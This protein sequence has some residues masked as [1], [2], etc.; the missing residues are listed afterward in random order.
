MNIKHIIALM[1]F[2]ISSVGYGQTGKNI[3]A[4][5]V[6]FLRVT[7]DARNSAIGDGGIAASPDLYAIFHNGAKLAFAQDK[8]GIGANYT[9]WLGNA[10]DGIYLASLAGYYKPD[11]HQALSASFRYFSMGDI[12]LADI[13]G[14]RIGSSSPT[15]F[16]LDAGYSRK[17]G[18]QFSMGLA[19]RYIHSKLLGGEYNGTS[20][21]A[22]NAFSGDL[23]FYYHGLGTQGEGWAAGVVLSNLG[24]K[25]NYTG[26]D[27]DADYLPANLGLGTSYTAVIDNGDKITL[28][29]EVSKLLVPAAPDS[30]ADLK[31][32]RAMSTAKSWFQ[33]FNKQ[34]M[35][36]SQ[37]SV[38]VEYGWKEMLYFRG[39]LAIDGRS[40]M[41]GD[42]RSY[43]TMGLGLHVKEI[44]FDFAYLAA[45]NA[46]AAGLPGANTLRFGLSYSIGQ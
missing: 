19:F 8:A 38:G 30:D 31:E 43:F 17:L 34:G 10:S 7:P 12:P 9:P 40:R 41:Y 27:G 16:A 44:A 2:G 14:N 45:E 33:S 20:Y 1:A 46:G 23:S 42:T 32:Y 25:I 6:P 26:T 21:S 28:L 15:E 5:A 37:V 13:N 18:K 29:G 3:V 36:T 11:E 35:Q 4:T 24:T 22:A 39:G